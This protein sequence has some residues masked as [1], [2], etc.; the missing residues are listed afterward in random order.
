MYK[1]LKDTA[2]ALPVLDENGQQTGYFGNVKFLEAGQTYD[3]SEATQET[4][5]ILIEQGVIEAV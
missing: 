1:A 5:D 4:I 3:L 2:F